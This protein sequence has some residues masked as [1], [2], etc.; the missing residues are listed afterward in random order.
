MIGTIHIGKIKVEVKELD[1]GLRIYQVSAPVIDYGTQRAWAKTLFILETELADKDESH[2][3]IELKAFAK[4]GMGYSLHK[5][6]GPLSE[7]PYQIRDPSN[8]R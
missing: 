4:H 6:N 5:Y 3:Q 2:A 7:Y 1:D 8:V